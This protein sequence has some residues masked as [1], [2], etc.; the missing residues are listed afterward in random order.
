MADAAHITWTALPDGLKVAVSVGRRGERV[1][2]TDRFLS[3]RELD[4]RGFAGSVR[5]LSRQDARWT[6][7]LDHSEHASRSDR[8]RT[9]GSLR[10]RLARAGYTVT[11][12]GVSQV[13]GDALYVQSTVGA[14]DEAWLA[15][16]CA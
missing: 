11:S 12:G 2:L 9:V 7:A 10:E 1:V 16:H 6:L 8:A 14:E 3:Q 15:R 4:A 5:V 13:G